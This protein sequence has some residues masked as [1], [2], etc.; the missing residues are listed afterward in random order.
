MSNLRAV[1]VCLVV[2]NV[3]TAL[4]VIYSKH[5]SRMLYKKT[6]AL[7]EAIDRARV[8]WGRLQIEESTLARYGR[9]E[10]I[11]IKELGM[12]MPEHDQIKTVIK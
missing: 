5:H 6:R 8:D 9:I 12:R 10:E 11:A 7:S 1:I 4:G 2:M 3:V